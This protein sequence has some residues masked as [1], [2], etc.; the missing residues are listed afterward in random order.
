[1]ENRFAI[2][3]LMLLSMLGYQFTQHLTLEQQDMI[4][5]EVQLIAS[6]VGTEYL[7]ET[8]TLDF[9]GVNGRNGDAQSRDIVINGETFA[10]DLEAQV[11]FMEKE[12]NGFVTANDETDFQEVTVTVEGL[13]GTSVSMSRIYYRTPPVN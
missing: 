2:L 1:M 9:A 11:R 7:E 10:F 8:G 3:A 5:S 4:R 6:G 12:T 13:L